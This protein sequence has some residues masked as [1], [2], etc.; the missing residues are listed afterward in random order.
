M[1][2]DRALTGKVALV[3]GGSRNIGRSV[4]IELARQGA[5]VAV[6]ARGDGESMQSTLAAIEAAGQQALGVVADV[7]NPGSIRAAVAQLDHR[8]GR[9]DC[10]ACCAAVRPHKPLEQ[11][12]PQDWR[13]VMGVNLD[14]AFYTVHAALSLLGEYREASIITFGGLSAHVG[15]AERANVIA[16]KMGVIGLTRALAVELAGRGITANCVVPGQIETQR[17]V[18]S[19]PPHL[20]G[21]SVSAARLG[22]PDEVASTVGFLAGPQA[23]YITGQTFHLNGGRYFG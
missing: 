6:V 1:S 3:T 22:R 5:D 8:F 14:G 7:A 18:G 2:A 21:E 19:P 20:Q 12:T 15:A 9:L 11:I 4:A 13:E 23:R 17:A 10:L 16:S